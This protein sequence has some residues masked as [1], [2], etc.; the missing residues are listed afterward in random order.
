V[1]IPI[2]NLYFLFTYAWGKFPAGGATDAGI[3]EC[4]DLPNLFARLLITGTHRLLRRGLD[5]DY[6]TFVEESRAPKGRLLIER[7]IKE[8]TLRR[9]SLICS[10]D[11]LTTDVVHNQ[12]IKATAAALSRTPNVEPSYRHELALIV[13]RFAPISDVHLRPELFRRVQLSRNTGQYLPIIKL[14]ELVFRSLLPDQEGSGTRFAD[15]LK[16]EVVMSA[17]FEDFLRNFFAYEQSAYVVSR[18]VMTWDGVPLDD[19]SAGFLPVMETDI[20]LRSL[21]RVIILDA[22]FYRQALLERHGGR[23][24]RSSHLYQLTSY[25]NHAERRHPSHTVAGGLVYPAVGDPIRLRYQIQ[26]RNVLIR[27]IDLSKD[28]REIHEDLLSIPRDIEG[29][30]ADLEQSASMAQALV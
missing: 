18:E 9:G 16:D 28:W 1:T 17:V 21:D 5:R 22:K 6:Q 11:E 3:D 7:I 2:R 12:I 13:K 23:K 25:L 27:S 29:A 30:A 10:Y 19:A 24:V 4:P 14:C 15:I 8:Q 26:G 20:T